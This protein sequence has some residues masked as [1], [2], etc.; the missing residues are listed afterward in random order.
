[1]QDIVNHATTRAEVA[2]RTAPVFVAARR[3]SSLRGRRVAPASSPRP[4]TPAP[5]AGMFIPRSAIGF[6]TSGAV[7]KSADLW[8]QIAGR[9]ERRVLRRQGRDRAGRGRSAEHGISGQSAIQLEQKRFNSAVAVSTACWSPGSGRRGFS[10]RTCKPAQT[11][12]CHRRR[13]RRTQGLRPVRRFFGMNDEALANFG[14]QSVK[15]VHDVAIA[16]VQAVT[17][18]RRAGSISSA[19]RRAVTR[20]SM[21]RPATRPITMGLLRTTPPTTSPCCIWL[22]G[23]RQGDLPERW[24]GLD[25]CREDT[26]PH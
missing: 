10:R 24:R 6:P 8:R 18:T 19:T 3:S 16:L 17:A 15:K 13:R 9:S 21:R 11:G 2:V 26:A 5:I 23:C 12:F 7:V 14:K 22:A 4:R 1:M 25:Q 20:R